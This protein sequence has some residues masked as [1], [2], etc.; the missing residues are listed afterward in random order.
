VVRATDF[1]PPVISRKDSRVPTNKQ[2][3]EAARR[4]LERQ[5]ERRQ[6][7]A[8]RRK[9][10]NVIATVVGVVVLIA[11][12][13][14]VIVM[15]SGDSKKKST[16]SASASPSATAT[17]T[18]AKTDGPC[19]YT[20]GGAAT[21]DV[22]VPP[23]PATTPTS[24]EAIDITSNLGAITLTLDGA[25]APCNVQSIAY[26]A[27]KGYYDNTSCHRLVDSGIFVLQCGDPA[28]D[29]SGGPGYTT[30]DESLDKA[31][32]TGVGTV[33]MANS[34][35][36]TNGSQFF[37]IFKDS[38]TGLQKSYT[39]IG[40]VTVG[41]DVVQKVAAAGE[42]A[43]NG[44]GD[45]K[46]KL[47]ITFTKVTATPAIA[48]SGTFVTRSPTGSPTGS[49]PATGSGSGSVAPQ[50]STGAPTKSVSPVS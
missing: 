49:A 33:A 34:G 7:E 26:L 10:R 29:G 19:G 3:R 4:H 28:G 35:A 22:G 15:A 47:P 23:D 2:R 31:D 20:Q 17:N 32:Y 43:S 48:G 46:P 40:K 38:S 39:V 41:L 44:A 6:Q 27:T 1:N 25:A 45:G 16:A 36:N 21:K 14:L 24:T 18:A 11:V 42:D 13:V 50:L 9:Q 30:K 12:V 5:L 37:I 8:A